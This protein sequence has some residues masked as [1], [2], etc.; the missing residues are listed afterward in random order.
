MA[1]PIDYLCLNAMI[2]DNGAVRIASLHCLISMEEMYSARDTRQG[3]RRHG[4]K[5]GEEALVSSGRRERIIPNPKL[6]LMDQVREVMREDRL[7]VEV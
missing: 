4:P 2:I 3:F 5:L 6:K 7:R 1:E